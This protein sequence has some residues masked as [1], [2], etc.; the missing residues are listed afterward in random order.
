MPKILTKQ[1]ALRKLMKSHA[2]ELAECQD[3]EKYREIS[4][5]QKEELTALLLNNPKTNPIQKYK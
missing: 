5:R 2:K 4:A 3:L 1:Q